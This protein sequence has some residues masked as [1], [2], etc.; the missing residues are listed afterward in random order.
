[1]KKEEEDAHWRNGTAETG[2][3]NVT[4]AVADQ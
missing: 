3:G 2:C 1:M 4:S